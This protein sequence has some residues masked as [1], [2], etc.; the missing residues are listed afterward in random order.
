[1]DPGIL[2]RESRTSAGLTQAEVARRVGTTQAAVARVERGRVS[3]TVRT[4]RRLLA[5]TGH[6]LALAAAPARAGIDES[7]IARQLRLSPAE[8]LNAFEAGYGDVRR[9]AG[10]ARR[11]RGRVA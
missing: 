6:E 1:M 4:L 7:L 9:L 11:A 10:A 3:P 5:A 8:R 2:L